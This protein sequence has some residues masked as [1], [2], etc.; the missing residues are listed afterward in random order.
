MTNTIYDFPRIASKYVLNKKMGCV[1]LNTS[2]PADIKDAGGYEL[3]RQNEYHDPRTPY[4]NGLTSEYHITV[5]YGILNNLVTKQDVEAVAERFWLDNH[6]MGKK[7]EIKGITMF[8]NSPEYDVVVATIDPPR[9]LCAFHEQM[10]ILP[11]VE[12]FPEYNP[13]ITL[14]YFHKGSWHDHSLSDEYTF[15]SEVTIRDLKITGH[16]LDDDTF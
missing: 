1:M 13:H 2:S 16:Y 7:L 8:K 15:H 9:W 6:V 14:G 3:L 10:L 11:G 12:T 4:V 5:K